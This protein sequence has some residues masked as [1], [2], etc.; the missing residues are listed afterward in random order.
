MRFQTPA[1]A[2]A[3]CFLVASAQPIGA[4]AAT[5]PSK[6]PSHSTGVY[7]ATNAIAGNAIVAYRAAGNGTLSLI[8]TYPTGGAG[9]GPNSVPALTPAG[10][11]PLGSQASVIVDGAVLLVVNAG[12][13]TI[14]T[15]TI[16]ADDTLT[17]VSNVSS[18]GTFP[19]TI[20]ARGSLVYVGN[21]GNPGKGVPATVSGFTLAP[22][23]ALTPIAN[24][25]RT[26]SQPAASVAASAVFSP[27]GHFLVVA[28]KT[29]DRISTFAVESD[30]RLGRLVSSPSS[31]DV[32]F[33]AIFHGGA[34]LVAETQGGLAGATSVTSYWVR[35]D[36]FAVPISASVP[37]GET[38]G[39]WIAA[40][41]SSALAFVADTGTGTLS[42]FVQGYDGALKL[43]VAVATPIIA[44]SAPVDL[45]VSADSRFVYQL[46]DG[47]G[48]VAAYAAGANGKLTA[49]GTIST[50]I[51]TSGAQGLAVY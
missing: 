31:G 46:Y 27:D 10:V 7:V 3:A 45:A 19:T 20:A 13:G 6:Y 48:L 30:G 35:H 38:A 49:V 9:V 34:L 14:S 32:P 8:G 40:N 23:G 25:T 43:G 4:R 15:F 5:I 33:A 11:D 51:P 17:K 28:D 42:T 37:S 44:G 16:A 22:N 18:G 21:A 39:C 24:S 12:S 41:G 1:V 36:G 29:A 26:L 50:D 47:L 2:L